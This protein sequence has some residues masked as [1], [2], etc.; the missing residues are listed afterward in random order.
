[1]SRPAF[2]VRT[3]PIEW[4]YFGKLRFELE[5]QV[6]KF[7]SVELDPMFVTDSSPPG[8]N[9]ELKGLLLQK[10]NGWGPLAG[11]ALGV[12]V[13]PGGKAMKNTVLRVIFT[14]YALNYRT[15]W[16]NG[17][18]VDEVSHVERQLFLF[19]GSHSVWSGFTIAGGFGL[20]VELNRQRRCFL[21]NGDVTQDCP[22]DRQLIALTPQGSSAVDLHSWAHPLQTMMRFS[23]GATF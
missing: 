5:M 18:T 20:G 13:W 3:D 9:S 14:N 8:T 15:K 2:S 21:N 7:I 19:L 23:L 11:A 1:M 4:L 12:G 17:E 16:F 6:Y 10:S 22:E